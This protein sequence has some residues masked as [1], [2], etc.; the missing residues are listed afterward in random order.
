MTMPAPKLVILTLC[1]GFATP[2][3]AQ[4][5]S[6]RPAPYM[7]DRSS[8]ETLVQSLYNAIDRKEFA[9][10]WDYFGDQKPA[11]D[12]ATF[13]HG[14]EA[15]SSVSVQTG[16]ASEEGAAGS[17]YYQVPVAIRATNA[18]GSVSGF[19][20]CYTARLLQPANQEP[21]FSP[22][23]LEKGDL[24]TAQGE[25]SEMLPASCGDAAPPEPR[26][27]ALDTVQNA[28]KATYG[29]VCQTLSESAEPDAS[30]AQITEL[31]YRDSWQAANEPDRKARLFRFQCLY[32]AY[33]SNQVYYIENEIDGIRQLQFAAPELDVHYEGNDPEGT[34]EAVN[35]IGY[36]T[37]DM[38]VNSE[39]DPDTLS[40][41][42]FNKWRGVGDA[43][44]TST[45]LFR[46][47]TFT[48]TKY[49]VDASYDG[50]VNPQTI[51][52]YDTAP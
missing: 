36:R 20:G 1:A 48:L 38:L 26:D 46:S 29:S 13:V 45:Y 50:E 11:P 10:A 44:S 43:S 2:L 47:G 21:P 5:E 35:V 8:A 6:A 7:D 16:P 31:S 18:D 23:H 49:E 14:Y 25:L 24:H 33:N 17:I 51:L 27:S 12:F 34:L 30:D 39:F 9:R 19:A 32:G 22:I 15:T 42:S 37:V 52:D 41:K 28:F 4:S 3:Y 40:L